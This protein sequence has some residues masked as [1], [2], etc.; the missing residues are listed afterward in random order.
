MM[1]VFLAH[2]CPHCNAE[3]R[4]SSEWAAI[5]RHPGRPEIVGVSTA[6]SAERP[7]YPPD[8]WLADKGWDWPVLADDAEQTAAQRLRRDRLPVPRRSSTPTAPST[9]RSVR[10]ARRSTSSRRS[11]TPPVA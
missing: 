8:E 5:G 7:N 4:C 10:R 9:A 3:S 2:W 11:P 6:V 1:V